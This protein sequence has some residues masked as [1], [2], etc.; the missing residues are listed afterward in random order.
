MLCVNLSLNLFFIFDVNIDDKVTTNVSL[1]R[2]KQTHEM[3]YLKENNTR[4]GVEVTNSKI[5]NFVNAIYSLRLRL[6]TSVNMCFFELYSYNRYTVVIDRFTQNVITGG[7]SE[8]HPGVRQTSG[9]THCSGLRHLDR[10]GLLG[11]D[12]PG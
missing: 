6:R 4:I 11:P 3:F 7:G 8:D 5:Y 10:S 12:S 1:N 2:S 9:W